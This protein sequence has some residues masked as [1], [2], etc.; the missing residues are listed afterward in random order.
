MILVLTDDPHDA[1]I[2]SW[3]LRLADRAL[4]V[5]GSRLP[6]ALQGLVPTHVPPQAVTSGHE[7]SFPQSVPSP[8]D[9]ASVT[10]LLTYDEAA[11][12]VPTSESTIRRL[13][14]KGDLPAVSIGRSRFVRPEDL[15]AYVASLTTTND[16][17]HAADN[18]CD[19]ERTSA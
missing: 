15:A 19:N 14:A 17:A 18:A 7:R 10:L 13:V 4:R 1:A 2:V 12:R 3:A 8:A 16:D 6:V 11:R 9:D 5:D